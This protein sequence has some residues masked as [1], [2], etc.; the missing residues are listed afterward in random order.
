[1]L[2][3]EIEVMIMSRIGLQKSIYSVNDI[4]LYTLITSTFFNCRANIRTHWYMAII[5]NLD[6]AKSR[7]KITK[8]TPRTRS[9]L[10]RA[11]QSKNEDV[12]EE[13]YPITSALEQKY[14]GK[15]TTHDGHR[16]KLSHLIRISI[17][18]L[19]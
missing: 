17:T 13:P 2:R 15:L 7:K 1:M 16:I 6:Q 8:Y 14:G 9:P 5:C 12:D 10:D 3:V 11:R 19:N 18:I 4:S